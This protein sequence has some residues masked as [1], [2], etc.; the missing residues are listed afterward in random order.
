M[1]AKTSQD[2]TPWRAK[3]KTQTILERALFLDRIASQ[4]IAACAAS[5]AQSIVHDHKNLS[6]FVFSAPQHCTPHTTQTDLCR[7]LF[8]G[9][10]TTN[11]IH[12]TSTSKREN[13]HG[14][15]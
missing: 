14:L 8:W 15:A 3:T 13:M 2:A 9:E 5:V 4:T 6:C 1:C 11:L 12:K 10:G 7:E